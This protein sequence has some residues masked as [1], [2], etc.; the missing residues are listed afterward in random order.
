MINDVPR[1]RALIAGT[2]RRKAANARRG[3]LYLIGPFV[4]C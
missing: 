1:H 3:K 2:S 4:H